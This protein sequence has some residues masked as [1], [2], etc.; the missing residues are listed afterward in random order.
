M[1]DT[2]FTNTISLF[3]NRKLSLKRTSL[4]LSTDINEQDMRKAI[5]RANGIPLEQV[6]RINV[7]A[8][9]ANMREQS[10]KVQMIIEQCKV[11]FKN[12]PKIN[13][14]RFEEL[15]D[16]G[17]FILSTNKAFL[18][19][20]PAVLPEYPDFTLLF[21]HFKI[22][23]EHTRLWDSKTR[24]IYKA[25]AYYIDKAE[26]IIAVELNHHCKTINIFIDYTKTVIGNG[27][28][29]NR[30]FSEEQKNEIPL[31]IAN[32]IRSELQQTNFPKPEF[33][34]QIEVTQNKD[35][36][37]DLILAENYITNSE[38]SDQLLECISKKEIKAEKYRNAQNVDSL[39]LLVVVDDVNSFSGLDVQPHSIPEITISN[40]DRVWL[41]EKFSGRIHLLFKN[42]VPSLKNHL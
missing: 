27:N 5:A 4:K 1:I 8:M 26:K 40:F 22:G 38:F 16:I 42:N 37:I 9:L 31:L 29:D 25:A 11:R 14:D 17:K 15:S 6:P 30:N 28:F 34:S 39:W 13:E 3:M 33:I 35:F 2:K 36:K 41:F 24:A 20:V 19:D 32:F 18:I 21:N 7:Y 23:V 12:E 10:T